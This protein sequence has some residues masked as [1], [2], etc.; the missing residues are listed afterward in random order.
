MQVTNHWVL[1]NSTCSCLLLQALQRCWAS[2]VLPATG[3][4]QRLP[5]QQR[6]TGW[7]AKHLF[8]FRSG[9]VRIVLI[10]PLAVVQVQHAATCI[11]GTVQTATQS[12]LRLQVLP[13]LRFDLHLDQLL[14]A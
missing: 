2:V 7:L 9:A 14:A 3:H 6:R 4:V 1:G 10:L 11:A 5:V 8:R 12:T 13:H